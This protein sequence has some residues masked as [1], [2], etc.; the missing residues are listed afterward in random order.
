MRS[1]YP[2]RIDA[3]AVTEDAFVFA[4]PLVLMALTRVEQTSVAAP[5]PPTLRA[6]PNRLVHAPSRRHAGGAGLG[7]GTLRSSA[8]LDLAAG[9]VVL[10]VPETHGRYYCLSLIDLWTNG[11]ASI[12]PRTTGTGAGAYAI[13][14]RGAD[15]RDLPEAALP[16]TAPTRHVRLA[17]ETCLERGEPEAAALAVARG[18]ALSG[19]EGAHVPPAGVAT[20][21]APPVEQVDRMAAR[22]FFRLAL[23]LLED[24]PPR[25]EDRRLME[26]ARQVGLLTSAGD[27]WTAGDAALQRSVEQGFER[28]RATLQARAA[29][30]L[31]EA[32]GTWHVDDRGHGFGTDY[33]RRAGAARAPLGA[34]QVADVLPAMT[35]TDAAGRPLSGRHRYM[36]R[37]APD[38]PPPVHGFWS[39]STEVAPQVAGPGPVWSTSLGDR[40][41]LTVDGDGSLRIHIQHDRPPRHRRSNWLPAPAGEFALVLRLHWPREELAEGR[42]TPPAVTCVA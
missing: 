6:P 17:G 32:C 37:F 9:P 33:L 20:S 22:R 16:V 35:H 39:L 14:L 31:E 29:A 11:F 23:Q 1:T 34:D 7:A 26:R 10:T 28:G 3:A 41:G 8:W 36:L 19:P 30:V 5:D 12:G 40:D 2:T 21:G 42:W 18:Y 25:T 24:N 38:A 13:G 15:T 4:Y 27:P